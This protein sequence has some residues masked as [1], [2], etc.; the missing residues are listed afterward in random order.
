MGRD[1][2]QLLRLV[3][4]DK[5][6]RDGMQKGRLANCAQMAREYEVSAKTIMR[7]IDYLKYQRDAPIEYDPSRKG[8]FY[9]EENYNLPALTLSESDLFA[10]YVAR[11][12]L[13]QHENTPVYEKLAAVFSKIEEA[14]PEKVSLEP[15]W[16]DNKI[17]FIQNSRTRIEPKVWDSIAKCLHNNKRLRVF[18]QK[19]DDIIPQERELDPYH[20][21]NYQGEWYLIGYCHERDKILTFAVSR[22]SMPKQLQQTCDVA[23]DFNIEDF[24][25][26]RFGIFGSNRE[27]E[28]KMRFEAEH[29]PYLL[30]REWHPSQKI[31]KEADGCAVLSLQVNHLYE[32]KRWVL[33]WGSGVKVLAPQEF[34]QD[35][36][37]ELQR[38]LAQY[39]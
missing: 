32:I 13:K 5:T 15:F 36:K 21:L 11:N 17:S 3:F 31:E 23:E 18:Y 19:T 30:E 22:M 16:V 8:Y 20:V 29:V 12:A 25:E 14:L 39:S 6:I 24:M 28:V 34:V 27:Y 37:K 2:V 7:D 10:I 4:I 1:K 38:S 26:K 9:T 35:I 33:T